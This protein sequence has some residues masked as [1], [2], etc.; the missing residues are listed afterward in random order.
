VLFERAADDYD[1]AG[2]ARRYMP[3]ADIVLAEGFSRSS[4]PRIEVWR[5]ELSSPPLFTLHETPSL[6][7]GVATDDPALRAPCSVFNLAD[8]A[9]ARHAAEAAWAGALELEP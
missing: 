3:E 6:W 1:P 5:K 2:L 9:W 8:A 7:L 4:L